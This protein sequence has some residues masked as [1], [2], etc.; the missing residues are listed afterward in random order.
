M[1]EQWLRQ[2]KKPRSP[3]LGVADIKMMENI[4]QRF[5]LLKL[6]VIPQLNS[7]MRR[8]AS[9]PRTV[10]SPTYCSNHTG[11]KKNNSVL[12]K[13]S[14]EVLD[15]RS[16]HRLIAVW[17]LRRLAFLNFFLFDTVQGVHQLVMNKH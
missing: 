16:K 5:F 9:E 12:K 11:L 17:F 3:N 14:Y 8:L 7:M 6:Q 2:N 13:I 10:S 4:V 15:T 1:C